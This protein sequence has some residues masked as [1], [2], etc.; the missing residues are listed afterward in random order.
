VSGVRF[1][2]SDSRAAAAECVAC[3]VESVV[4]FECRWLSR[5]LGRCDTAICSLSS[6][7]SR[8]QAGVILR[9]QQTSCLQWASI[10]GVVGTKRGC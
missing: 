3:A 2:R 9:G 1:V 6:Y 8:W 4:V 7:A 10:A 5:L